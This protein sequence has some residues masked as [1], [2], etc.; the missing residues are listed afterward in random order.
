MRITTKAT[1]EKV[2]A[3]T[4]AGRKAAQAALRRT[5]PAISEVITV[6]G[7]QRLNQKIFAHLVRAAAKLVKLVK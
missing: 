7:V 2:Y 4:V 3:G 5:S 1:I 6:Q